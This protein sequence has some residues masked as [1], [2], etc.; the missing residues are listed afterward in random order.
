VNLVNATHLAES[1]EEVRFLRDGE[2]PFAEMHRALESPVHLFRP[3]GLPP[4]RHLAEG[5]ALEGL[6]LAVHCNQT[7]PAD[8][9]LLRE[10]GVAVCLC[11]RSAAFF[12]HPM[13]DAAG[14]RRAGLSLCLG[15]D[16]RASSPSLSMLD[17]AAAL[18]GADPELDAGGLLRLCTLAGAE[19]LG[20]ADEGVGQLVPGGVADFAAVAAPP[21]EPDLASI[22]HPD[23][24]V[25]CTVT[26]GEIRFPA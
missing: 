5:G 23:A 16:S 24:R 12:G 22:F 13:A 26:G 8:W 21:G 20:F 3:R 14:M 15:T 18:G 11:P 10:A 2:G 19:A 9:A 17:E 25:I 7:G 6:R 4:V 1:P